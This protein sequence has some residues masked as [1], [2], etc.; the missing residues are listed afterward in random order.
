MPNKEDIKPFA[1]VKNLGSLQAYQLSRDLSKIVWDIVQ[2][3]DWFS[4]TT[5]GS[6]G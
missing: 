3:M 6:N 5:I 2:N 1:S 4:K